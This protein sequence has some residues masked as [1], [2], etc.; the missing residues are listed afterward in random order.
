MSK[1]II[2]G[3]I[4]SVLHF[5]SYAMSDKDIC[6]ARASTMQAIAVERDAGKTKKQVKAIMKSKFGSSLPN[7]FDVYLDIV[8]K[9]KSITPTDMRT[10][11][12]YSCY[13]EFGLIK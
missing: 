8:Y 12:L 6:E 1:N 7:S 2:I 13:K 11:F 3:A 4:F 9:E 10:V 5:S